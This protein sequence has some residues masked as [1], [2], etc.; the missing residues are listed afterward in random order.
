LR[1]ASTLELV[2]ST[3][4]EAPPEA[5]TRVLTRASSNTSNPDASFQSKQE[6]SEVWRKV[7]AE[8]KK[9]VQFVQIAK[10]TKELLNEAFTKC[11]LRDFQGKAKES[12]RLFVASA[13][14]LNESTTEPWNRLAVPPEMPMTAIAEWMKD[15][16]SGYDFLMLADGR[17]KEAYRIWQKA[18][19]V[20]CY[21][22]SFFPL[23]P[24]N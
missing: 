6:R 18:L 4:T 11:G 12:H 15:F 7:Q 2:T 9:Y 5:A 16:K 23:L 17:S 24:D 8:R 19:I 20:E 14:L 21:S 22:W 1:S 3:S 13:D 10:I